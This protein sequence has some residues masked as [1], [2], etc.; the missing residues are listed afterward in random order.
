MSEIPTEKKVGIFGG[1]VFDTS[2]SLHKHAFISHVSKECDLPPKK[3]NQRVFH[4][5][6]SATSDI[7]D[8]KVKNAKKTESAV[9]MDENH[10]LLRKV[11]MFVFN[12]VVSH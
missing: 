6:A 11:R 2:S 7:D 9:P 5:H 3:R 10:G 4:E 8:S 1:R 12:Q